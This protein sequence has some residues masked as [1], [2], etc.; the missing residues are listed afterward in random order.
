MQFNPKTQALYTDS[1]ELIKVLH[2]PLRKQWDQL[3]PQ[4]ATPHRVCD[5]CARQILNT[6]EMSDAEVL[7][8][9]RADPSTCLAVDRKHPNTRILLQDIPI[10]E[11]KR[12][13]PLSEESAH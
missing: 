2:C 12:T 8:A 6:T 13:L 11:S 5:S 1:G 9:V 4:T 10:L 7:S 3:A